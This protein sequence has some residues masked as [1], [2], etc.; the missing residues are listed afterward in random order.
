MRRYVG[1]ELER[2]ERLFA[3]A[4]A[5]NVRAAAYPDG[6]SPR[7]GPLRFR[8]VEAGGLIV[9]VERCELEDADDFRLNVLFGH[10]A[11]NI[12]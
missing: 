5:A 2:F 6:C 9:E 4:A 1:A 7:S 10:G 11:P 12:R 3:R 8:R